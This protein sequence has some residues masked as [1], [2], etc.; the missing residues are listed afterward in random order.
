MEDP[1]QTAQKQ[2]DEGN[3]KFR[4]QKMAEA[5]VDFLAAQKTLDAIETST[6][7]IKTMKM[8]CI[9]SLVIVLQKQEK[10]EE[11]VE[12]CSKGLALDVKEHRQVRTML[13]L[14]GQS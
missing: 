1:T 12:Q 2:I 9:K 10:F 11:A 4:A 3:V 5:E 8:D 13:L 6:D 7:A 14:R